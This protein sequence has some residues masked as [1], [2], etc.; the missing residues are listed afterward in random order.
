MSYRAISFVY[1]EQPSANKWNILGSNDA[2]FYDFLGS[3]NTIQSY[4]PTYNF[5]TGANNTKVGK[6]VRIGNTVSVE[7]KITLGA[8]FAITGNVQVSMPFAT[9]YPYASTPSN[10]GATG[11]GNFYN[12]GVGE[13]AGIGRFEDNINVRLLTFNTNGSYATIVGLSSLVPFTWAVGNIIFFSVIY[14]AVSL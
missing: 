8:G 9:K 11:Y 7:T 12:S 4:T 3:S 13:I 6:Y 14:E 2:H 10:R 5:L 1:G